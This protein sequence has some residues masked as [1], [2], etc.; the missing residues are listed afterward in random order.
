MLFVRQL[1]VQSD[2]SW[3]SPDCSE[4]KN[5]YGLPSHNLRRYG[6]TAL[7]NEGVFPYSICDVLRHKIP[8]M[9]EVKM[10]DNRPKTED[11]IKAKEI[12]SK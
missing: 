5:K 2:D 4:Y 12:I 9:T 8:G 7:I 1:Q 6:I 10:M 3:G 11:I